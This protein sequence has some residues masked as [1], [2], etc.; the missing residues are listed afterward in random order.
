MTN[1][2][3]S[4]YEGHYDA[5]FALWVEETVAKLKSQNYLRILNAIRNAMVNLAVSVKLF[6]WAFPDLCLFIFVFPSL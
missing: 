5:D 2:H 4:D 6:E 3:T 1:V